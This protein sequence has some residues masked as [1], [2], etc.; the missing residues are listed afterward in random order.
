[1]FDTEQYWEC[2]VRHLTLTMY[3]PVGTCAV[4]SV[5]DK[6]FRVL[7][8]NSLYIADGSVLPNLPSANPNAAI[9]MV[10]ERAAD[11]ILR[12]Q[13]GQQWEQCDIREIFYQNQ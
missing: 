2:Y 4:G 12:E 1:M 10:A 8:L 7:G 6:N 3:H 11:A 5:V 9:M 13:N